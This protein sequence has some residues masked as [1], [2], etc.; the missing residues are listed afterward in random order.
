M[1]IATSVGGVRA[2]GGAARASR[3]LTVACVG[4]PAPATSSKPCSSTSSDRWSAQTVKSKTAPYNVAPIYDVPKNLT[5]CTIGFINPGKSIP[6]FETWSV[7]M[8]E[9][10]KF[11]GVTFAEDDV[12]L[13]YENEATSFQTMSVKNLA[14]VGAHPGNPALLAAT[15]AANVPLITIDATVEGNPYFI[16]VPNDQVGTTSGQKAAAAAKDKL[17]GAWSGKTV[18]FI[19][20]SAGGCGACDTRVQS[21]LAAVKSVLTIDDSNVVI[22]EKAGG[23][24]TVSQAVVTNVLTGHPNSVFVIVGLN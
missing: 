24:P 6:F 21:G 13:K 11:Y 8:N 3:A 23:D 19:G 5:N 7:A 20:L 17:S 9:A 15:K 4:S 2:G 1:S 12:K 16:G 22:S 10:A 14:A 18:V